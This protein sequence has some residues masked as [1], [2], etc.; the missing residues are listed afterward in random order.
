MTNGGISAVGLW[1]IE[2]TVTGSRAVA[3][4]WNVAEG[5]DN[6]EGVAERFNKSRK[7]NQFVTSL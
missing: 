2:S 6:S 7:C 1:I 3:V 5:E 4:L